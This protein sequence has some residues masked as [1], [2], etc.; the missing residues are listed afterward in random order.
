MG[1]LA[2]LVSGTC[3]AMERTFSMTPLL[4]WGAFAGDRTYDEMEVNQ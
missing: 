2:A 3:A 4:M 1:K